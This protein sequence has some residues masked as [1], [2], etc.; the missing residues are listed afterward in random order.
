MYG[1]DYRRLRRE[2]GLEDLDY[3]QGIHWNWLPE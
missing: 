2:K 1:L 3:Q